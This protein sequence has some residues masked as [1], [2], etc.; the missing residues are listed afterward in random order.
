MTDLHTWL[1]QA[2]RHLAK[3][4]V[5]QVR[6][7]IGE[8]YELARDAAIADGATAEEAD[9]I[10]INALGDA[11]VA[12]RQYRHVLLTAAEARM[13]RKGSWESHAV[14]SRPW[15]KHLIAGAGL[16]IFAVGAALFLTGHRAVARDVFLCGIGMSPFVAALLLPIY[17]PS[18]GFV[19]RCGKWIAMTG[20]IVLILGPDALKWS[21]LLIS[22]LLPLARM[23]WTRASIRRKLPAKAWPR[24]LYL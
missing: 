1:G 11:A 5:A 13:L 20:T 16:A 6:T 17:T 9:R 12:N 19:F 18:R 24:H 3:D 4:G 2:T 10:A 14:C 22:S 15:L 7:E 8:H 21:W 23:E